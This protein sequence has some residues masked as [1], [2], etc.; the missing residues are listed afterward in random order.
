VERPHYQITW[1]TP[2][3]SLLAIEP[4]PDEVEQHAAALTAAYND[5]HNAPLLGHT[6]RMSERDVAAY[7][8]SLANHGGRAFLV[9]RDG[10]LVA[11]G[12]LRNIARG[13]AEFAFM[14]AEVAEQGKG[15]GTRIA[16][17]IHMFAFNQLRLQRVYASIIPKN[18]ASRRVFEKLGY[19]IET[20][21]IALSYAEDHGD[22]VMVLDRPTFTRS[23]TL[24]MAEIQIAVR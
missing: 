4:H 9:F 8:A 7:Y 22:I 11:D 16:T 15:L 19:R 13:T 24:A 5:P 3:G 14:V 10:A 23:H 2:G 21:P 17:M 12:D 1:S 20:G 18:V 6:E